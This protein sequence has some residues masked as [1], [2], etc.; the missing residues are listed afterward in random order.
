[1]HEVGHQK[2][3]KKGAEEAA[4]SR[5]KNVTCPCEGKGSQIFLNI[6][7]KESLLKERITSDHLAIPHM[8][9]FQSCLT[10]LSAK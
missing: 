5:G 6:P 9:R 2:K 10:T 3:K 1:M 4:F 8:I 7:F